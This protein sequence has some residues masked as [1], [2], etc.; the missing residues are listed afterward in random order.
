M[1]G[2]GNDAL[3]IRPELGQ[4]TKTPA[5]G[6]SLAPKAFHEFAAHSVEVA[7]EMLNLNGYDAARPSFSGSLGRPNDKTRNRQRSEMGDPTISGIRHAAL[8][9]RSNFP[10][11]KQAH[12]TVVEA[13]AETEKEE[14]CG[15]EQLSRAW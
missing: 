7:R 10:P 4:Q 12:D 3:A 2:C 8:L 6:I 15:T 1:C 11:H 13:E 5:S 9:G 14:G